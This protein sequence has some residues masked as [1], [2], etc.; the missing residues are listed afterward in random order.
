MAESIPSFCN[1]ELRSSV[2]EDSS[3]YW[4]VSKTS[5]FALLC[6][7]GNIL[8]NY[9]IDHLLLEPNANKESLD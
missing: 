5:V 7:Y 6:T 4:T 1:D 9:D 3:L 8:A 2:R